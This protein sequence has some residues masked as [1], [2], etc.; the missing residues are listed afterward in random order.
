MRVS[1]YWLTQVTEKHRGTI[2]KRVAALEQDK[3][4]RYDSAA[5]LEAI[6]VGGAS[7][8]GETEFVSTPEAVRQL[9]VA[10]KQQIELDM[11]ITRG[12][13]IPVE[14]YRHDFQHLVALF[15]ASLLSR[16]GKLVDN[17]MLSACQ[18]DLQE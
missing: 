16:M 8:N 2:K 7:S 9:T 12:E 18:S 10:K 1:I 13:R 6:Y 15:R 17:A 3:H 14:Q 11:Q 4:R 5:A